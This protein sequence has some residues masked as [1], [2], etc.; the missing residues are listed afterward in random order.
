MHL[1]AIKSSLITCYTTK[2]CLYLRHCFPLFYSFY[3]FCIFSLVINF[4]I[5]LYIFFSL[6]NM[7]IGKVLEGYPALLR[8]LLA[9]HCDASTALDCKAHENLIWLSSEFSV[10]ECKKYPSYFNRINVIT[11]NHILC[12]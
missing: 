8:L 1:S 2:P 5:Y 11:S 6:P 4:C 10:F 3:D 7:M 12:L 9:Q